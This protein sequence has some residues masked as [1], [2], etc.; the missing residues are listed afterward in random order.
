MSSQKKSSL[1]GKCEIC[2]KFCFKHLEDQLTQSPE[3]EGIT[4][5]TLCLVF[6]DL[7]DEL[8]TRWKD[9]ARVAAWLTELTG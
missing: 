4:T 9:G 8:G 5:L 1:S 6:I 3:C 2:D 7:Y